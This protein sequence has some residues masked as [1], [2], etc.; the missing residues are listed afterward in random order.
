MFFRSL[1]GRTGIVPTEV[2]SAFLSTIPAFLM[3]YGDHETRLEN[4]DEIMPA[5]IFLDVTGITLEEFCVLRDEGRIF[6]S[7]ELELT[8]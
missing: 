2:L 5:E 8:S 4:F 7:I 3:A 1:T 6:A